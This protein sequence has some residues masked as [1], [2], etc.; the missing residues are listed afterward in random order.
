MVGAKTSAE[1]LVAVGRRMGTIWRTMGK[2]TKETAWLG[3]VI[4]I[5]TTVEA[6]ITT[7]VIL[8]TS[9][10]ITEEMQLRFRQCHRRHHTTFGEGAAAALEDVAVEER[11]DSE[12]V[13]ALEAVVD[14]EVVGDALG[15][16]EA[17]HT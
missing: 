12:A 4:R 16:E 13:A 14:S 17:I 9:R 3:L 15:E 11:E 7:E 5:H 2:S 1:A 10:T 8:S 6:T